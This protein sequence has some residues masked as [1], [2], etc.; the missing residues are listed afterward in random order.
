MISLPSMRRTLLCLVLATA[1]PRVAGAASAPPDSAAVVAVV[2]E[3]QEGLRRGAPDRVRAVLGSSFIMF[4]GARSGDPK[5]WE[6]HM[7]LAGSELE[8]WPGR[9]VAGSGP[10]ENSI[11]VV[12]VH[13]RRNAALVVTEETGR[14]RFRQWQEELVTYLL[15]REEGRWRI[16]GY[17]IRDIANPT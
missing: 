3:Y 7:Y 17:F 1:V 14:N 16:V 8:E 13:V 2:E 6:V 12:R 4:N 9:F 5:D 10:H 15:G 11:R